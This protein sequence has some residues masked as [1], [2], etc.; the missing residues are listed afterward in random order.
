[1]LTTKQIMNFLTTCFQHVVVDGA[2]S[3]WTPVTSGVLQGTVLGP[4]LFLSF[5]NNL[6]GGI[7]SR[8]RLLA[9]DCLI[10]R[11]ISSIENTIALQKDL[12]TLH[13]WSTEWNIKFNTDKCH[14]MLVL[15]SVTP[16]MPATILVQAPSPWSQN[17]RN[18]V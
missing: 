1:M 10:Y 17:I 7:T 18:L 15:S 6:P 5:I 9:D 3:E 14:T 8:L 11:P 2:S 4:L 13:Q 12:D 16:S